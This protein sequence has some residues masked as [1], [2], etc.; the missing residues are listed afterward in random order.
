MKLLECLL[1]IPRIYS[2]CLGITLTG[3]TMPGRGVC[4]YSAGTW[5]RPKCHG[6]QWQHCSPLCCP[7][8]EYIARSKAAFT[9]RQHWSKEQGIAQLYLQ[10]ICNTWLFFFVLGADVLS[11]IICILNTTHQGL[12]P[13]K[14]LQSQVTGWRKVVLTERAQFC[15]PATLLPQK[16][17]LPIRICLGVG[18]GLRAHTRQR[19]GGSEVRWRLA[20]CR[21]SGNGYCWGWMGG[22]RRPST[23]QG[24]LGECRWPGQ[25]A[26]SE[27]S[28]TPGSKIGESG[29]GRVWH[30]A[31][32][33]TYAGGHLVHHVHLGVFHAQP[34]VAPQQGCSCA[35]GAGDGEA[36]VPAFSLG[37]TLPPPAAAPPGT[38][39]ADINGVSFTYLEA[40]AFPEWKYFEIT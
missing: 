26:G 18:G 36:A 2:L 37:Y 15:L 32:V 12:L 7:L 13:W 17:N 39:S 38:P 28:R 9:W 35:W 3:H 16:E 40:Q 10:N 22:G 8:S 11:I 20:A 5:C 23:Q 21:G 14:Q 24:E 30:P 33:F 25:A 19:P 34:R 27:P 4:N 29:A 6:C 31:R 1:W